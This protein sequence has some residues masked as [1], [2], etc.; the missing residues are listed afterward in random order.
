MKFTSKYTTKAK[1]NIVFH[2][3]WGNGLN[4]FR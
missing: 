1:K 2:T 4:N 3:V